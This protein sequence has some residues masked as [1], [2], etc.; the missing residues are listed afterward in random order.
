[1]KDSKPKWINETVYDK[2]NEDGSRTII[3]VLKTQK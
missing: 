1:M 3:I 2:K